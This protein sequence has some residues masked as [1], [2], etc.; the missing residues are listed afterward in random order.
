MAW[1][2]GMGEI[3]VR[4][5]MDSYS[6]LRVVLSMAVIG[7][8]RP[9]GG[10]VVICGHT[11][12]LLLSIT[13]CGKCPWPEGPWDRGGNPACAHVSDP[14]NNVTIARNRLATRLGWEEAPADPRPG[15]K[16]AG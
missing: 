11:R 3:E 1:L 4:H 8:D 10:T 13:N 5:G 16:D 6:R 14:Y 7:Q 12:L 15:A 2:S 9:V